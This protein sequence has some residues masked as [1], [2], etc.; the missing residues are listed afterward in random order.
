MFGAR[1]TRKISNK[2][3]TLIFPESHRDTVVV[4]DLVDEHFGTEEKPVTGLWRGA[5]CIF[6]EEKEKPLTK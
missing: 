6:L 2:R 4:D 5:T 3:V 1:N